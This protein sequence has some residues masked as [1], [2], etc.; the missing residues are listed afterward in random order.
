MMALSF[1]IIG[2]VAY[3]AGV[4][5]FF[6]MC[7][8]ILICSMSHKAIKT[9]WMDIDINDDMPQSSGEMI[10]ESSK[11]EIKIINL[12]IIISIHDAC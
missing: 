1:F 5:I 6:R 8:N 12:L 2:V 11:R 10:S 4:F 7:S 3:Q 9:K